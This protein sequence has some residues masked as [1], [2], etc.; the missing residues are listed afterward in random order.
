[1]TA[2]HHR[3]FLDSTIALAKTLVI[4][5][6]YSAEQ[7]NNQVA[8]RFGSDVVNI[9]DKRTWKYYLNITG[10]YHPTDPMIKVKS[11]DSMQEID[12]TRE[13]LVTNTATAR[14]YM[15]GSRYYRELVAKYPDHRM[16]IHGILFPA[17][18]DKA[19]EA[20][21]FTVLSY[22]PELV[23]SN[24]EDLIK[25]I[26]AW[27]VT[28][29]KRWYVNEFNITDELYCASFLL[30][31][32]QQLAPLILT[33][34]RKFCKTSQAHSYHVRQYLN[35]HGMIDAYID[36][37][38]HKQQMF[39]Y[40]NIRYIH[41]HAGKEDT[42]KWLTENVLTARAMPLAQYEA[43]HKTT[44]MPDSFL[45]KVKFRARA[46]TSVASMAKEDSDVAGILSKEIALAPGNAE[47]AT[48]A[49]A[50]IEEAFTYTLFAAHPT[51]VL[52]SA[53]I[54]TSTGSARSL[55]DAAFHLWAYAASTGR[56]N[57]YVFVTDP[58]SGAELSMPALVAYHYFAYAFYKAHNISLDVVPPVLASQVPLW[59]GMSLPELMSLVDTNDVDEDVI[60]GIW[61]NHPSQRTFLNTDSFYESIQEL[62]DA[63]TNQSLFVAMPE[64]F[65]GRAMAQAAY[66]A[67]YPTYVYENATTGTPIKEY[68]APYDLTVDGLDTTQWQQMYLNIFSAATGQS[69]TSVQSRTQMQQTMVEIMARLSS[70]SVQFV[71][72]VSSS[73]MQSLAWQ[74]LRFGPGVNSGRL[75]YW[76]VMSSLEFLSP[77]IKADPKFAVDLPD[78][79]NRF[80]MK[81]PKLVTEKIDVGFDIQGFESVTLNAES[82]MAFDGVRMLY[83]SIPRDT[84]VSVLEDL[85]G[86]NNYAGYTQDQLSAIPDVYSHKCRTYPMVPTKIDLEDKFNSFNLPVFKALEVRNSLLRAYQGY[87]VSGSLRYFRNEV[88]V[89]VLEGFE[90]NVGDLTVD[91]LRPVFGRNLLDMFTYVPDFSLAEQKS[92]WYTGGP[93]RLGSIKPGVSSTDIDSV[94]FTSLK[95]LID[96]DIKPNAAPGEIMTNFHQAY[97]LLEFSFSQLPS[98]LQF[99]LTSDVRS[100]A[101]E[102]WKTSKP[103]IVLNIAQAVRN[104]QLSNFSTVNRTITAPSFSGKTR[105]YVIPS[106]KQTFIAQGPVLVSY[107]IQII[108]DT[109]Q[110]APVEVVDSNIGVEFNSASKVVSG[111]ALEFGST[112]RVI[113]SDDL[114]FANSTSVITGMDLEFGSNVRTIDIPNF[115]DLFNEP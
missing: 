42:F 103:S 48:F 90:S 10:K 64:T 72:E 28:Q 97:N 29:R 87:S 30:V 94:S 101:I 71:S 81:V 69:L 56:Y 75:Y 109:E 105:G 3:L 85:P 17:D 16:L 32:Y 6:E 88:F 74:S 77:K 26:N 99:S 59:P 8:L 84:P 95:P 68:F 50:S 89:V 73:E 93:M 92:F 18:M 114:N 15:P 63:Q 106:F 62:L 102:P 58:A 13:N 115:E 23:E 46:L 49:R 91:A 67:L 20:E 79:F 60:F 14:G 108:D 27:L 19:I 11:L 37:M 24:E 61:N 76:L 34:R 113:E 52:E 111:P 2:K 55:Q 100:F 110:A 83:D 41:R 25:E 31:M 54:Q 53:T 82:V 4:K 12:F 57:S 86:M 33:L 66:E 47:E 9:L 40:R 1:M 45:P 112:T 39:F 65:M 38:T 22:P 96:L 36:Q 5:S 51:K 70:Y 78:L 35:S 80:S 21:D 104:L 7:I 44:D 107:G 43:I 98:S